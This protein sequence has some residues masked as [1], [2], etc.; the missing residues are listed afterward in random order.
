[1]VGLTEDAPRGDLTLPDPTP[2][3][4]RA[5]ASPSTSSSRSSSSSTVA[6][7]GGLWGGPTLARCRLRGLHT[8]VLRAGQGFLRAATQGPTQAAVA[9]THPRAGRRTRS[10][11]RRGLGSRRKGGWGQGTIQD[12]CQVL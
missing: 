4:C 12:L 3:S 9:T 7:L 10:S 6:A 5:L 2:G 8:L 1:M 11:S